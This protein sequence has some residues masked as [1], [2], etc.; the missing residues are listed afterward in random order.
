MNQRCSLAAERQ[1]NKEPRHILKPACLN[2]ETQ[3]HHLNRN[4]ACKRKHRFFPRLIRLTSSAST[5]NT[6]HYWRQ[7]SAGWLPTGWLLGGIEG[8][9]WAAA[10]DVA[11]PLLAVEEDGEGWRKRR[12]RMFG[13]QL[14]Y[15]CVVAISEER[16][17]ESPFWSTLQGEKGNYPL[18]NMDP[19]PLKLID[20]NHQSF[21]LRLGPRMRWN[22]HPF[23]FHRNTHIY[24]KPAVWA[25]VVWLSNIKATVTSDFAL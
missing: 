22:L 8:G 25:T 18:V 19:P 2:P 4:A 21:Q 6:A 7:W 17:S 5:K 24:Q 23:A 10:R 9:G 15:G 1:E 13:C 3:L 20:Q 11:A 16:C 14:G 12:L